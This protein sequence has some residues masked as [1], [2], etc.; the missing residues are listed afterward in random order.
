MAT[1]VSFMSK[2]RPAS[3]M[4]DDEVAIQLYNKAA[5]SSKEKNETASAYVNRLIKWALENYKDE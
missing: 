1:T 5:A 4:V 2:A 3:Y